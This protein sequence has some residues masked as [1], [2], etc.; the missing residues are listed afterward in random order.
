MKYDHPSIAALIAGGMSWPDVGAAVNP[1]V[2]PDS[3]RRVHDAW[4]KIHAPVEGMEMS[5]GP[6]GFVKQEWIKSKERSVLVKY[7]EP[8]LDKEAIEDTWETF[9]LDAIGHSPAYETPVYSTNPLLVDDEPTMAVVSINDPHIGML[10]WGREVGIPYDLN[11]ATEDYR[12]AAMG[13]KRYLALY[14]IEAIRFVVGHDLFHADTLG[15]GGK[16]AQ[17]TKGTPQDIDSRLGKIFTAVRRSVVGAL[18]EYRLVAPVKAI[19]VP[20]NHDAQTIYK[21]GEVLSAWYRND[22]AVEINF[23]ASKR[24]YDL[25]GNT[26]FMHTHGEEFRR[27]RDNLVSVFATE[28]PVE[29]WAAAKYREVLVGH[30]HINMQK[31]YTGDP[32]EIEWEGRATRVRSLPG[33]TPEDSWHYE[34]GYKH[35]RAATIIVYRKSGGV[36]GLHEVTL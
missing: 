4:K 17:T 35:T 6:G 36:A 32:A 33:L 25:Y 14:N 11:I 21:F 3:I 24:R 26:V 1:S 23:G 7:P 10:A 13:L 15:E 34:Q 31:I 9:K 16:G 20:G 30:N 12:R 28:C 5:S 18:D 8:T 19:V 27:K 22:D 29:M 2:S